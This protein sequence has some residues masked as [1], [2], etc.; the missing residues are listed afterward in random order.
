M[1]LKHEA[2]HICMISD[3]N[4]VMPTCV[5]IQSFLQSKKQGIYY[6]HIVA[7]SLSKTTERQFKQFESKDVKID[8]VREDADKRFEG[9]HKFDDG[10]ICV[11]SISAL[12]KFIIPDLFPDIDKMLYLDGDLIAKVDLSEVYN[13]DIEDYYAAAVIDSGSMYY[14]HKYVKMVENY[15]NSGVMVLNLKRLRNENVSEILLKT[16]REMQDASLMDQNVFNI[17]FDG[18]VLLLPIRYN[19]MPVSLERAY[20]K[21]TIR[22]LNKMYGTEYEN[23]KQLF[24]DAAIIHYSSKD[25]PWKVLDGAC[26]SDWINCYLRAPIPH[27]LVKSNVIRKEP[28]G[29]SVVMPCFN[30]ESYIRETLESVLNQSFQDFEIICLDDGSTDNTLSILR[31]YEAEHENITVFA[32]GNFRQGYE[33]N[34]GIRNARGKYIYYMDSDD[35]LDVRCFETI[36]TCA[37]EN[38]LDLLYFEGTSFY[39]TSELEEKHPN[40]KKIYSRKEAFP[41]V[42]YGDELYIKLRDSGG[43]IVSPCL[44]LVRRDYIQDNHLYFPELPMLEDNLYTFWTILKANRVKCLVDVLFYR[45]VRENSTMTSDKISDKVDSLVGILREMIKE[46]HKYEKGSPMYMTIARHIQGYYKMLYKMVEGFEHRAGE[47]WRELAW[48]EKMDD[49][50][51]EWVLT[52]LYAESMGIKMQMMTKELKDKRSQIAKKNKKIKQLR[53]QIKKMEIQLKQKK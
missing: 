19:F 20:K 47:P 38:N 18:N 24:A 49:Y 6:I 39:E 28:Y 51:K 10:A 1:K 35:L 36:Y 52:S 12:L 34:M 31:Q 46:M 4:Y 48:Y 40:Y 44:Q 26:S 45:R 30:V 37:E 27:P 7:S 11:A 9:F 53:K 32:N 33:R 22:D 5:A 50:Q 21:W 16:K 41:K 42:Y 14:K 2:V 29:I 3:D 8:I 43:L 25:K 15:F 23:K 17:V 13:Y